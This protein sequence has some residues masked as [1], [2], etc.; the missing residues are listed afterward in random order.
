MSTYVSNFLNNNGDL[1]EDVETLF[2]QAEI[3]L[4]PK[5]YAE[6][7]DALKL[8]EIA[9]KDSWIYP[10]ITEVR[11]IENSWD[12]NTIVVDASDT[13]R[14]YGV[15]FYLD[16]QDII[17]GFYIK[18]E[19]KNDP[20]FSLFDQWIYDL[21]KDVVRIEVFPILCDY[22]LTSITFEYRF[23][24]ENNVEVFDGQA[25][26]P[27]RMFGV[28]LP[29]I[30]YFFNKSKLEEECNQILSRLVTC[31]ADCKNNLQENIHN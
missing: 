12:E 29:N 31:V 25:I 6:L 20:Y 11:V 18:N 21:N 22:D 26:H 7:I 9:V 19:M 1:L 24:D 30:G 28:H 2:K 13:L 4:D 8:A 16:P 15:D 5:Y 27:Y 10:S 17:P 14:T 3:E 23:Y